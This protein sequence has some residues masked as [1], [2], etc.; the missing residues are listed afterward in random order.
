[1]GA[2]KFNNPK[3]H[4][5]LARLFN[6]V[7]NGDSSA[8]FLDAFAGS[9]TSGHSVLALNRADGGARRF[10]LIESEDEYIDNLTCER[11]RRVIKG[12]PKAKDE[13]LRKG[14]G[15][16]FSFIEMGHPMKLEAML[17]AQ[18]LPS[19]TDLA[20]YIFYT[21]TGEDFDPRQVHPKAG[22]IGESA[23]YDVYL[24]YEPSLEYLKNTAFI[25]T[26]TE[27]NS[28]NCL[29]RFIRRR[30]A[31]HEAERI[32]GADAHGSETLPRTACRLAREGTGR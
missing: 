11:L 14:L 24:L 6:Y 10:V 21:A 15:G 25:L 13:A 12:I 8:I 17:K 4:E 7:T 29:L 2:V 22:F 20:G 19:Y 26:S 23:K 31:I 5:I 32:S 16:S 3:D 9:A 27:L 18:E 28:A 1:M 30:S